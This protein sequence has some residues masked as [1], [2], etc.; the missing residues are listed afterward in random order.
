MRVD[1]DA[2]LVNGGGNDHG[3]LEYFFNI[4]CLVLLE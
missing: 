4:C 1:I 3:E 2:Y